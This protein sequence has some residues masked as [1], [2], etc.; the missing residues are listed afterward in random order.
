ML[1]REPSRMSQPGTLPDSPRPV[2]AHMIRPAVRH[3]ISLLL[4]AVAACY[5]RPN[6]ALSSDK[7]VRDA[8]PDSSHH[9]VPAGVTGVTAEAAAK[10]GHD[11]D[12]NAK[13]EP[14]LPNRNRRDSVALASMTKPDSVLDRKW[15]VKMPEAL[16]GAILPETAHRRLLRQPALEEDGRARRVSRTGD[17]LEA[18]SDGRAWRA[19]DPSTPVV[20]GDPP[21]HRRCAGRAGS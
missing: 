3:A 11:A 18:R 21:R 16:E 15:R 6:A 14:A 4:L 8:A 19:A 9:V 20:P 10:K 5:D 1:A 7:A 2:A 13:E 12:P 17:A